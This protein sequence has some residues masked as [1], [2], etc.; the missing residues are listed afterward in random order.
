MGCPARR[1]RSSRTASAAAA[2][3][4]VSTRAGR[5]AAVWLA[6]VA[7]PPARHGA[8]TAG[9]VALRGARSGGREGARLAKTVAVESTI[10]LQRG[11]WRGREIVRV[12]ADGGL[13]SGERVAGR[14][15]TV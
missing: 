9:R 15:Q 14:I 7:W 3:V 13:R 6:R 2:L 4:R 10:R 5:A 11:G 1:G 12:A 8:T